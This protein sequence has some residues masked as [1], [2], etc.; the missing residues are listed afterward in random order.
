V[1]TIDENFVG[2]FGASDGTVSISPQISEKILISQGEAPG[3]DRMY[4]QYKKT[5]GWKLLAF[6]SHKKGPSGKE[7]I[8]KAKASVGS[9]FD[10]TLYAAMIAE[11]RDEIAR[12]LF[13]SLVIT[14]SIDNF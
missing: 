2:S 11:I 3:S 12:G 8:I 10:G 6:I 7:Y 5:H 4:C 13:F 14:H 1:D 9:T